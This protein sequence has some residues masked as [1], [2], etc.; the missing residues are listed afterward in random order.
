[1]T[2]LS[3]MNSFSKLKDANHRLRMDLG[4]LDDAAFS[5]SYPELASKGVLPSTVS[6]EQLDVLDNLTA[7]SSRVARRMVEDSAEEQA[8]FTSNL[9]IDLQKAA[10]DQSGSTSKEVQELARMIDGQLDPEAIK[11]MILGK[12][13]PITG[14][15]VGRMLGRVL[16]DEIGI[17]GGAGVGALLASQL[18]WQSP[19]DKQI[20]SLQ[21]QLAQA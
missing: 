11:G 7:E 20:E 21:K 18:G 2:Q 3:A 4:T 14:E 8:N 13:K 10:A 16:G 17:L 6:K 1:M 12:Q 5:K 9:K 19:K 15:H